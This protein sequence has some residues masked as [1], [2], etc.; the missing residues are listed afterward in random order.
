M[1]ATGKIAFVTVRFIGFSAPYHIAYD[2]IRFLKKAH[3]RLKSFS[4]LTPN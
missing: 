1:P 3:F 4:F 2:G